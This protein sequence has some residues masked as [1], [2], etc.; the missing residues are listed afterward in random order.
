MTFAERTVKKV[1]NTAAALGYGG[2]FL[3][4]KPTLLLMIITILTTTQMDASL[5]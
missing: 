1:W 5:P 4:Q 3:F 2:Q